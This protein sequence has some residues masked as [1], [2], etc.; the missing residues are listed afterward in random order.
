M[1]VQKDSH[2]EIFAH[3]PEHL[4]DLIMPGAMGP[5]QARL[6]GISAEPATPDVTPAKHPA[7]DDSQAPANFSS[8]KRHNPVF[9][10]NQAWIELPFAAIEID[11]GARHARN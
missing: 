10:G 4:G 6:E 3:G 9:D 2:T 8:S 1:D 5:D 11:P 7:R